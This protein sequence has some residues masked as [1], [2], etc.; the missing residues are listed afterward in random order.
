MIPTTCTVGGVAF[1]LSICLEH[2]QSVSKTRS[3]PSTVLLVTSWASFRAR[4]VLHNDETIQVDVC[5]GLDWLMSL[6]ERGRW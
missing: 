1:T 6:L 2:A 5:L 4:I 3:G